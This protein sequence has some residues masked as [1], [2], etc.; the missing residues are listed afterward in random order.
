[1]DKS[2][3]KYLKKQREKI[4]QLEKEKRLRDQSRAKSEKIN[5]ER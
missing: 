5:W 3:E 2:R 1:L 4:R